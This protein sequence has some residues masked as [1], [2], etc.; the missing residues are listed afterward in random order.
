MQGAYWY[1][2]AYISTISPYSTTVLLDYCTVLLLLLH[3]DYRALSSSGGPDTVQM[4]HGIR[5]T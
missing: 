2:E 3:L 4:Q 1:M 5:V